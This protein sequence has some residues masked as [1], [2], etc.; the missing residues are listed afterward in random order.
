MCFKKRMNATIASF[1]PDSDA[2]VTVDVVYA[3][4][5]RRQ[6]MNDP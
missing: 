5:S 4:R 3:E 2:W 6:L 1:E